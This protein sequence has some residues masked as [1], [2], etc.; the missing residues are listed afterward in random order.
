MRGNG[1]GQKHRGVS[2]GARQPPASGS[3]IGKPP[4]RTR[5]PRSARRKRGLRPTPQGA[6][7]WRAQRGEIRKANRHPPRKARRQ[8]GHRHSQPHWGVSRE[9][10]ER[11]AGKRWTEKPPGWGELGLAARLKGGLPPAQGAR[12]WW[13][14]QP[15]ELRKANRPPPG[16]ARRQPGHRRHQLPGGVSRRA[17]ERAAGG[18]GMGR[19]AGRQRLGPAARLEPGIG[20]MP[21]RASQWWRAA[22]HR[23]V[24][25]WPLRFL[26][27]PQPCRAAFPL[28]GIRIPRQEFTNRSGRRPVGPRSIPAQR[29]TIG[30]AWRQSLPTPR[31]RAPGGRRRQPARSPSRRG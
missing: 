15:G 3:G 21:Q 31:F 26:V 5:F 9:A 2:P 23:L 24:E 22:R 14:A 12:L 18:S 20:P 13:R 7:H 11:P 30:Q 29:R 19:A 4:G 27:K 10:R 8:P 25:P 28:R 1:H 16:E 17:R 6:R